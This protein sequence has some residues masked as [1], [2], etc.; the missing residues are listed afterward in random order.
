MQTTPTKIIQSAQTGVTVTSA[1]GR[2]K[3][4]FLPKPSTW[5]AG[6]IVGHVFTDDNERRVYLAEVLESISEVS[7]DEQRYSSCTD[8][9]K[10]INLA[11]GEA[12]PV[13]E[14]VVGTD[15]MCAFV[16]AEA[17]GAHFYGD[18]LYR[19]VE[20]RIR[21]VIK[22]LL[23]NNYM[24]TAHIACGAAGG[25]TTVI[26]RATQF[27]RDQ[28]YVERMQALTGRD[29]SDTLHHLI[30]GSYQSRLDSNVYEGYRDGLVSEI[31]QEMVGGHAVEVYEDDGRGVHG[32]REQMIVYLDESMQGYAVDPN[33]L[34]LSGD[35]QVF[36]VNI[37]RIDALARVMSNDDQH[38]IDYRIARLAIEDFSCAGHGTL[39][40]GI[41]TVI[42]RRAA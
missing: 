9:R 35:H 29:Y 18:D 7:E 19:P 11:D 42:V 33:R 27:I 10:R 26:N 38:G 20:V 24:P 14:Q 36:A 22:H 3:A 21:R 8:G 41:E 16:A 1:D 30:V 37:S 15:T 5:M 39:A 25:F 28:G 17:L 13:R 12:V 31:I 32:H 4:Q 40:T 6:A 2:W 34:I 23:D